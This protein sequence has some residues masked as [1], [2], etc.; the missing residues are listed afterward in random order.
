MSKMRRRIYILKSRIDWFI[1]PKIRIEGS[2]LS[3]FQMYEAANGLFR[4]LVLMD[5]M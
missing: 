3:E 1:S 5:S 4:V 2:S